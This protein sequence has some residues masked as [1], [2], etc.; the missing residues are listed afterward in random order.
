MLEA[1]RTLFLRDG[2]PRTGINTVTSHA[3]VARMTLYNNFASKNE[4]I[5][6]VFEREAER[7]REA[8]KSAQQALKDPIESVLTLFAVALE[9]ASREGFRGCAFINLAVET[10]APDSA[11]H[12]LAEQHKNWIYENVRQHLSERIFAQAETLAKQIC[13]LWDGGIVGAYVHQSSEPIVTARE[14]ARALMQ[15]SAL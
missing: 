11:L 4:L 13:V 15:S 5:L 14:T 12:K 7:R 10:A 9:L 2:V 8:I 6:A 3:G 1:G